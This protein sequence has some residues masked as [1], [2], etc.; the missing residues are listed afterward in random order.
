MTLTTWVKQALKNELPDCWSTEPPGETDG[1]SVDQMQYVMSELP[2]N[3]RTQR[4]LFRYH[5]NLMVSNFE[6]FDTKMVFACFDQKTPE[7]KAYVCH[8]DR[9]E[10]RCKKCKKLPKVQQGVVAGPEFFDPECEKKEKCID[11]QTLWMEQGPYFS[12]NDDAPITFSWM[13]FCR[14]SRNLRKEFYPRL[15]NYLLQN[16]KLAPGYQL[17]ISGLPFNTRITKEHDGD[18]EKGT[19]VRMEREIIDFWNGV[20]DIERTPDGSYELRGTPLDFTRT[21]FIEGTMFRRAPEFDHTIHEADNAIFFF[22]GFFPNAKRWLYFINDGD[23]IPIGL[24]RALEDYVGPDAFRRTHY[25]CL[26]KQSSGGF[27]ITKKTYDVVNLSQMVQDLETKSEKFLESGV[28]S[29]VA[30]MVFLI[31]LSGTDFFEKYA[32][33][34]GKSRNS[35]AFWDTFFE[36]T[37]DFSH[38]VQYYPNV[39]DH[40]VERRI[41]LDEETYREFVQAAFLKKYSDS[42]KKKV[43]TDEVTWEMIQVHCS[44][45]KKESFRAPDDAKIQADARRIDWN[46]NYWVNAFRNIYIDPHRVKDG[47]RYYGYAPETGLVSVVASKQDEPDEVCKRNFGRRK[48]KQM[49]AP[50]AVSDKKKSL[51]LEMIKG[52]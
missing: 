51:V 45:L 26:P 34:D 11:N 7:V 36:N 23:A 27:G 12:D 39:K 47:Q 21:I 48:K 46:I 3:V 44:N 1:V 4:D 30:S 52:K 33:F 38:L 15:A 16:L 14:D 32:G 31:I 24:L 8:K 29:P 37:Q 35:D 49:E 42:C 20:K 9:K 19:A 40:K 10:T 18:W 6:K 25:L 2:R 50:P 13:R 28:Q 43:K 22:P 17:F 5:S 41:V